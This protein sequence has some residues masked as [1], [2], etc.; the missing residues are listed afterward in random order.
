[1]VKKL[2]EILG[3][4]ENA[5]A[6]LCEERYEGAQRLAQIDA[7]GVE[8][9]R[10]IDVLIAEREAVEEWNGSRPV[11]NWLDD[12]VRPLAKELAAKAGFPH[13]KVVGPCGF[14]FRVFITLW[15]SEPEFAAKTLVV[16]PLFFE[17]NGLSFVYETGET[18]SECPPGSL[19]EAH[20][21]NLVTAPLPDSLEEILAV[22]KTPRRPRF[23]GIAGGETKKR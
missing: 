4:Y 18:T 5:R 17:E 10:Q 9:K 8:L 22:M 6:R 13:A 2:K 7:K 15:T 12:A 20:G 1:M 3:A 14:A 19:G 21:M 23:S 11:P 16:R